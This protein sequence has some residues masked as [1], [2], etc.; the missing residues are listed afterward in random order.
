MHH[1]GITTPFKRTTDDVAH[2]NM[3]LLN[4]LGVRGWRPGRC[5]PMVAAPSRLFP[6]SP[7]YAVLTA[8]CLDC[9]YHI[10]GIP[11]RAGRQEHIAGAPKPGDLAGK[12]V[13]KP[14]S[15]PTA[16]GERRIRRERQGEVTVPASTCK[17]TIHS[18]ARCC[19]SPRSPFPQSNGCHP[20]AYSPRAQSI[21][22]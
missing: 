21:I 6:G 17:H 7:G 5:Q 14:S 9:A 16:V 1:A 4:T 8:R 12:M 15:L 22:A 2:C 20:A 11:A 13:S 3:D 18:V 19:A 10:A